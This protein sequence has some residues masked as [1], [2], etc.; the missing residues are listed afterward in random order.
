MKILRWAGRVAGG[1]V[2]VVVV[3]LGLVY[4]LSQRHF[5]RRYAVPGHDVAVVTDS[6]TLARGAHVATTRGCAGCHGADLAGQTFIDAPPV[7]RLYAANLTAGAGGVARR[8]TSAA[9]WERAIRQGV[10][11]DGRPLFFMPS[12]EFYAIGDEDLGALIAYIQARPAVDHVQGSQSIGPIGRA[13]FLAGKL[14]LIP[15]E[16][17]DHAAPRPSSPTPGPTREYGMYLAA[18]CTGCHGAGLSGGRIPGAPPAMAIP[19]NITPDTITGIGRWGRD[20]FAKAIREGIRP[21]GRR[22]KPDMP[23]REYA[24]LS[25]DEVTAIWLYL[26]RVPAKAFGGR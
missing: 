3:I 16:L 23:Y 6:A 15:A 14:P 13:L 5:D 11:P 22:L 17:V 25:D 10:A 7:A 9:D 18:T 8:Y 24:Q 1:L 19:L 12:Q 4:L 21:D 2:A 26:S 20:D